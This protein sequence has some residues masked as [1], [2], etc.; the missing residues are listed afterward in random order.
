VWRATWPHDRLVLA[1]SRLIRE[2]DRV[3]PGKRV[4]V[5]ANR[6]LA[7][8]DGTISTAVGVALAQQSSIPERAGG[9]E[10]ASSAPVVAPV[11]RTRVRPAHREIGVTRLLAGDLAFL[12]D[13]GGLAFG[14]G[15]QRPRIMVIVG[16]DGGGTIFDDLEV[17][18]ARASNGVEGAASP[19]PSPYDRVMLTPQT[20][21]IEHLA[22]AYGWEYRRVETRGELDPALSACTGPTIVEVPLPR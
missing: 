17:A 10:M 2:L 18:E 6:G 5:H 8:I 21:S 4:V 15:E 9:E 20:A 19:G 13:V 3:A 11:A 12:H 7:G 1:A 22:G 14:E 16:N